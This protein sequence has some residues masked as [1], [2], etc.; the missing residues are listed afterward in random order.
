MAEQK[1]NGPVNTRLKQSH[2]RAQAESG[3]RALPVREAD[4]Y[5]EC[6]VSGWP[7]RGRFAREDEE[8]IFATLPS[9]ISQV[10]EFVG[11]LRFVADT[12]CPQDA[13]WLSDCSYDALYWL[14][15][16][17]WAVAVN[18]SAPIFRVAHAALLEDG[19]D[20]PKSAVSARRGLKR[21]LARIRPEQEAAPS[22][23]SYLAG[24]TCKRHPAIASLVAVKDRGEV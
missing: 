12:T 1:H 24:N 23:P 6:Y 11:G 13:R 3:Q 19:F 15:R 4:R 17:V 16:D 14:W 20:L 21:I 10:H 18:E 8:R 5:S 2:R 7:E 22:L 9:L